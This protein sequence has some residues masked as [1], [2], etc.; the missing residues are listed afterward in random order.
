MLLS[1]GIPSIPRGGRSD[2]EGVAALD[3]VGATV[4]GVAEV[5]AKEAG[6]GALGGTEDGGVPTV[7]VGVCAAVS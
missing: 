6:V 1:A 2:V 3:G 7:V 5:G 4:D